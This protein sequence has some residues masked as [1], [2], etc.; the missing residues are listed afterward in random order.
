MNL[1]L[2]LSFSKSRMNWSKTANMNDVKHLPVSAHA[3]LLE[4]RTVP[5]ILHP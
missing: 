4:G 2:S 1:P 3:C 5:I